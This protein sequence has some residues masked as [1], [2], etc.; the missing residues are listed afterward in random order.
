[1][2][3]KQTRMYEKREKKVKVRI[4]FGIEALRWS[5]LPLLCLKVTKYIKGALDESE[6]FS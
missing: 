5:I 3:V 6:L 4:L 1:M 2:I